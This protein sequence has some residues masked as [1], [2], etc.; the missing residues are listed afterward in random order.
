MI[1]M[2]Y[3]A[4]RETIILDSGTMEGAPYF[5]V[6]IGIHPCAYLGVPF[7]H[8]LA[9]MDYDNVPLGVHGGL[10]FSQFGE[11]KYLPSGFYWFG[12]DYGHCDDYAE[13][14]K[15]FPTYNGEKRKKWTTAEIRKE[16]EGVIYDFKRLMTLAEKIVAK[17][18]LKVIKRKEDLCLS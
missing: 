17:D 12:W 7:D 13:Y 3:T 14:C 1:E 5:I 6:S 18:R 10:T 15:N 11:G 2:V 16:I 8:P 9:G 4:E